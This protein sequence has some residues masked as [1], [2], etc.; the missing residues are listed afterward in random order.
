MEFIRR[1][2]NE[3]RE[4]NLF[5]QLRTMDGP[6][7]AWTVI[8]GKSMLLLASN[9]YLGLNNHP[10][11][12]S[13]MQGAVEK[14]GTGSGGSRLTTGNYIVHEQ[15]EAE[16]ASFKGTEAAIVFNTGYIANLGAISALTGPE[17]VVFS[18][19]FNHASI[20]DGCRLAK[21]R[22]AVYRHN[23]MGDLERLLQENSQARRKLIITDGVF[24]MDGD[25]APL[26]YIVEL[27]EHY[28][29]MVMVDDAH[30]TGVLGVGGA[31]T[32]QHF[33]LKGRVH[34]QMGTLSKALAST[35]GYVAGSQELIDYLRNKA[36]S[37]IFSTALPPSDAAAARAALQVVKAE[38]ERRQ[39]LWDNVHYLHRGLSSLGFQLVPAESPILPV[40]IGDAGLT[41]TVAR[42]LAERGVF[43]PGIRPPTVPLGSSR[44]R[45]TVMATH[46]SEDLNKAIAVFGEVGRELRII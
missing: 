25:I 13:A 24:S 44:I 27:A 10:A 4:H 8:D 14:Y 18:D 22:V 31:G 3:L 11:I 40:I 17:D 28:G 39:K 38:P 6:Q 32:T 30:A 16:L 19:E 2:L 43:A 45:V 9:S 7:A 1:E 37:F 35:G 36:R 12:I 20:I 5:R 34:I 41:I 29:A 21:A 33:G 46:T 42:K 15:L 23:D 26:N